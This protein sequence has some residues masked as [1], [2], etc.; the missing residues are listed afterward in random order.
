MTVAE[1]VILIV[2]ALLFTISFFIPDKSGDRTE[3]IESLLSSDAARDAITGALD[4][5]INRAKG[6]LRDALEEQLTDNKDKL[7][8]YMDRITNEK[9]MA[10][11]EYS[12]TVLKQIHKDHEEAVFLYDMIDNKYSMV[13]STAAELNQL[14]NRVKNSEILKESSSGKSSDGKSTR[15]EPEVTPGINTKVQEAEKAPQSDA[16]EPINVKKV[17]VADFENN[18]IPQ[19]KP[20]DITPDA[21]TKPDAKVELMF[22]SELGSMNNND[23]ILALH[24][25][26]KSNMAIAK[27]LDL[28]VGEVK[29]VLDLF[30]N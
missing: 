8:R 3:D 17:S 16:F 26:G 11:S 25:E 28:G 27:E 4:G 13:K 10:V 29:L 24:K 15:T 20:V 12:D 19:A 1:I 14:Q 9:M 18:D 22:D 23:R 30:R 7:D 6:D 2:G 5:E 21:D